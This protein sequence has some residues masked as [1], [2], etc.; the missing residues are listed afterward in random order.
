VNSTSQKVAKRSVRRNWL[1]VDS[2]RSN[3]GENDDKY[4]KQCCGLYCDK[5]Q[6]F[7]D[8][9]LKYRVRLGIM[10]CTVPEMGRRDLFESLVLS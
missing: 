3:G 4:C 9:L 10:S 7:S 1:P 2:N 8:Y 5:S 6:I